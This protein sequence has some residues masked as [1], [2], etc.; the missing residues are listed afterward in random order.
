MPAV[1]STIIS[2]NRATLASAKLA[3]EWRTDKSTHVS[4]FNANGPTYYTAF[5]FAVES[6]IISALCFTL[7]TAKWNTFTTAHGTALD[8][9]FHT[10]NRSAYVFSYRI[11]PPWLLVD[12]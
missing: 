5:V 2:S 7:G 12:R 11:L 9:T 1:I 8:A 10:A 4:T 6:T 3:T